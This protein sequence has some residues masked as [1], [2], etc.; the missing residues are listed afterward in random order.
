MT[1]LYKEYLTTQLGEQIQAVQKQIT[2]ELDYGFMECFGDHSL[3]G[4]I[5]RLHPDWR[6]DGDVIY[7]KTSILQL[8]KPTVAWLEKNQ[9][10]H[11]SLVSSSFPK[12][13][14]DDIFRLQS[15]GYSFIIVEKFRDPK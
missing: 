9:G 10:P 14:L 4:K 12:C 8:F 15:E 7:S 1:E 6:L 11:L 13:L 5:A 3:V 2:I